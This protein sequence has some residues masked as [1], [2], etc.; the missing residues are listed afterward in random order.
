MMLKR[1]FNLMEVFAFVIIVALIQRLWVNREQ[2]IDIK[3]TQ[4]EIVVNLLEALYNFDNVNQLNNQM[5]I[6]KTLVTPEVF[7]DLTIDNE[8]RTLLTY[9]KFKN[10]KVQINIDKITSNYV[11]Y[12][13]ESDSISE[14]REFCFM[15]NLNEQGLIDYVMEVEVYE[16]S[17]SLY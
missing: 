1:R 17:D 4:E 14:D 9:F 11:L 13:F 7:S 6:V 5:V 2:K 3:N 12:H 8:E 15:Y 10:D 16:F